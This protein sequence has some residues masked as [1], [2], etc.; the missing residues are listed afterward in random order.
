MPKWIAQFSSILD[1]WRLFS[2]HLFKNSIQRY[3]SSFKIFTLWYLKIIKKFSSI[4]YKISVENF[5][6]LVFKWLGVSLDHD[7]NF[8]SFTHFKATSQQTPSLMS[9]NGNFFLVWKSNILVKTMNNFHEPATTTTTKTTITETHVQTNL[10][11]DP[12]Y[13][14]TIPGIL[15]L[16]AVVRKLCL[17]LWSH[18]HPKY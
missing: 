13:I 12:N 17:Y 18:S 10:R 8:R 7:I 1:T 2:G 9:Q 5:K 3:D 16:A 6:H 4:L 15:K 14:K 11:W